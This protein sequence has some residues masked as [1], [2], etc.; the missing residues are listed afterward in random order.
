[1]NE[2][3]YIWFVC[4]GYGQLAEFFIRKFNGLDPGQ[5]MVI[6]PEGLNR[7]YLD[8][9]SG[10]VAATWMTREAREDD[11]EDYIN[12]LD[13]LYRK[14]L[15]DRQVFGQKIIVLGF[16][17]GVATVCRWLSKGNSIADR[18]I[19]WAGSFP[20]DL[21]YVGRSDLLNKLGILYLWGD[22][23]EYAS[24]ENRKKIKSLL[25]KE[26]IKA[27]FINYSGGH[28]IYPKILETEAL[29]RL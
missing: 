23:D 9:L 2:V 10:R 3:K 25:Q 15:D 8:G 29:Q 1:M 13:K 27:E 18:L 24:P 4:H 21:H 11:I 28:A 22:K 17:Q 7:F 19:L 26:N 16:S 14:I 12:F 5:H 20:P 6:A